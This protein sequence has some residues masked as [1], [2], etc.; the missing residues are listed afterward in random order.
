MTHLIQDVRY[1]IRLLAKSPGFTVVAVLTLALGIGANTAIFSVVYSA[2]LRPLPY[3]QP[4][5]LVTLSELRRQGTDNSTPASYPDFL[6]WKRTA[7]SFQSLAGYSGET[8]TLGGRIDPENVFATRVSPNFFAALGVKP[9]LGRDFADGEDQPDGP[10]VA[11]LTYAFW[12]SDF[13]ADPGVVGRTIELDN[14]P[15]TVIG[16]L[17]REFEFAPALSSP[18]WVPFH[19][20]EFMAT[21][22]NYRWMNVIGRLAPGVT[23]GQAQAEM[24]GISAQL[25]RAYPKEDAAV[26]TRLG[27]LQD[28]IVGQVR[29]LLL[30]LFGAVGFVLLIAC[31][32]VGNLLLTRSMGRRKEFAVRVAL[33]ASRGDLLSQLLTESLL[34]SFAGAAVGFAAAQWGVTALISAIPKSQLLSMPYL[35]EASTNLPVLFFLFGVTVLTGILFGLAPGFSVAHSPAGEFLKDESRGGTS[36]AHARVRNSLVVAEIAISLVL[37]V[38]A[39]LVLQSLRALLRQDPGF[40]PRNM[41]TFNVSLPDTSY[42][43]NK[44]WPYDIPGARIFEHN[45]SDRLRNLPGVQGV[46]VS[47]TLP[48]LGNNS[49]RFVVEGRTAALGQEDECDI[50]D[51]GAEYFQVMKIPLIKG[52]FFNRTDTLGAP[53]RVIV[54]QA[55]VKDFLSGEDPLGKRIRF[56]YDPRAPFMEIAGMV[57]NV[58]QN[59]LAA[60]APPVVYLANDQDTGTFMSYAVRTSG[61]PVAFVGAVRAALRETDPQI[62]LIQPQSMDQIVNQSPSVFLRRYPSY[63]IGSF[64]ALAVILAMVGLYGLISYTVQQRTREIGIRVALG[65][66]RP[67][68][69]RLVLRQGIATALA[70]VGIGVLAGLALTR[71]MAS[72]LFGVTPDDGFTF[73]CVAI[74]LTIVALAASYLPARRAMGVDPMVALRHE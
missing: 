48:L 67:D 16:I 34:L 33:G 7:K 35:R 61:D 18:L 41:L 25:A 4:E 63:L 2:L 29:P 24:D 55:F 45:F 17:P 60:P 74:L 20:D 68:I 5:K 26:Y 10:H 13:S 21:R 54:N 64:A 8:F 19:L 73:A 71:L 51:I 40:D 37:L 22:R 3:R 28:R 27:S 36:T 69:L 39:G 11:I 53:Q 58:A 1:G 9:L 12:R 56:T 59:D 49:I 38:G 6:D 70:G 47:S 62:A 46:G 43:T 14:K 15:V 42:P 32:N 30:I 31:A 50:L 66:Q 65:A 44:D 52:R 23:A 72:L 57:G